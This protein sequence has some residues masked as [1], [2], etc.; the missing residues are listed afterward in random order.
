LVLKEDFNLIDAFGLIDYQGKGFVTAT[1]IRESLMDLGYRPPIDEVH[2]L[3]T[4][5]GKD[6]SEFKYSDFSEAFMP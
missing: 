5:F 2:L 3:F 1:E 6:K 4:R